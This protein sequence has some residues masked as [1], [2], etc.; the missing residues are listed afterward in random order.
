MLA[1]TCPVS[2]TS[3]SNHAHHDEIARTADA[4]GLDHV[5]WCYRYIYATLW[6]CRGIVCGRL[7]KHCSSL[8]WKRLGFDAVDCCRN[9]PTFRRMHGVT[10]LKAVLIVTT[11][12]TSSRVLWPCGSLTCSVRVRAWRAVCV[13]EPDVMWACASLTCCGRVRAWRAV[14]VCEPNVPWHQETIQR[15]GRVLS[16]KLTVAQ[17]LNF[18]SSRNPKLNSVFTSLRHWPFP[19]PV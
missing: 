5:I 7:R 1:E 18:P 8:M 10:F 15:T 19:E 6:G 11:L 3:G 4:A 2:A 9:V 12:R 16:V 13:C 14:G 17:L